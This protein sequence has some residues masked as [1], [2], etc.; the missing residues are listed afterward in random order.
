M[1]ASWTELGTP[2]DELN[3]TTR[4]EVVR[5]ATLALASSLGLVAA[6]AYGVLMWPTGAS[7]GDQRSTL[8][9][10][11]VCS[12]FF[13][14][15]YNSAVFLAGRFRHPTL[16]AEVAGESRWRMVIIDGVLGIGIIATRMNEVLTTAFDLM[17]VLPLGYG[18]L[19][20]IVPGIRLYKSKRAP[21]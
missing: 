21:A 8:F 2:V 10:I 17:S 16:A 12:I 7:E 20:I 13:S 15:L 19:L 18:L 1:N 4:N 9:P 14:V 3:P 11:E 5:Y 6:I